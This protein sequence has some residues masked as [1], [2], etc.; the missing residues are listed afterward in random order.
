MQP[1]WSSRVEPLDHAANASDQLTPLERYAKL[2]ALSLHSDAASALSCL[3]PGTQLQDHAA[4]EAKA[5]ANAW[6]CGQHDRAPLSRKFMGTCSPTNPLSENDKKAIDCDRIL[7]SP[8]PEKL[9][10][11]ARVYTQIQSVY[12]TT[13]TRTTTDIKIS[14]SFIS[15]MFVNLPRHRN[16]VHT[17]GSTRHFASASVGVPS[18]KP[19][20][21]V[22]FLEGTSLL[23]KI[24]VIRGRE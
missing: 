10:G 6:P 20:F 4:T 18:S 17:V 12:P 2:G 23:V 15:G 3:L 22:F 1:L 13:T 19:S 8:L 14:R 11:C 16:A 21:Q 24:V 5:P 9:R 7:L